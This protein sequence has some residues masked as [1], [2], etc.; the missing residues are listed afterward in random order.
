M[1]RKQGSNVKRHLR[2]KLLLEQLENRR[3]LIA[4][5]LASISGLVFDDFMG[6][7][8][9]AGEEVAGATLT[10]HRDNGDGSFQQGT[11]TQVASTSTGSD[12]RYKFGRLTAGNYF[13]LQDAQ[14]ASGKTLQRVVSPLITFSADAV[15]GV[16]VREIDTF[17]ET[18]QKVSDNTNDGIPE[19]LS[20]S[21]PE[22]IGGE[23]DM[24]VNLTSNTGSI[25][26]SANDIALGLPGL[27]LFDSAGN[28]NGQRRIT[29]DGFDADA[30]SVN[31][32]GLGDTDLTS[33]S[34]ALGLQLRMGADLPGGQAVVRLYSNDN[35]ASTANRYSTAT[36]AI[37]QTG[38]MVSQKEFIPFTSFSPTSGGG[39]DFANIGAIELEITGA[40]NVNGQ[41]DII[42]TVGETDFLQ[43]F[44]NFD[45]ADL[46]LVKVADD[47]TPNINQN[48][49]F[50]I[51]L[52]NN[53]PDTATNVSV[54]DQLPAGVI[55]VSSNPTQGSYASG[56]GI[57]T[58][59]TVNS[60]A[61]PTLQL[62]GRIESAGNR[63]NFA[64]VLT[65]D[66]YDPN[67]TPGNGNQAEENDQA[68]V[69][70]V[71]ESIDLSL[72]KV[73]EPT[74]IVIGS[75]VTFTLT[76]NNA[77]PNTATGV[78]VQDQ[79][80]TGISFVSATPSQGNYNAQTA[81][82]ELGSVPSGAMPTLLLV[83]RVDQA[84]PRTN[85]AQVLEADQQD[86]DSTPGNNDPNEDDQD[87]VTISAPLINLSLDKTVDN[88]SP[89]LGDNLTFTLS[90]TNSGPDAGTDIQV[91]DLL[92]SGLAYVSHSTPTGT[93]NTATGIWDVGS[94]S[95]TGTATLTIV[96]N[97]TTANPVTNTAEVTAADQPDSNSTPGN[98]NPDEDDQSSVTVAAMQSDL[99]LE[100]T[101]DIAAPNLGD[102]I[103]FEIA[104]SNAGPNNATGVV[105]QDVLPTGLSFVSFT[106][107]AGNYNSANSQWTIG[108]LAN[109]GRQTLQLLARVD[110]IDTMLNV[111]EV[112]AA[113]QTDPN[114]TPGNNV[115]SENDQ[116][117][118]T[119]T[120][121]QSDLSLTK[122][123]DKPRAN[124][125]ETVKFTV[126][127]TNDGPNA[128][129]NVTVKDL[130][131]SGLSFVSSD[132]SQ[133]VY[134]SASGV[135]TVGTI[136]N[137]GTASL[138]LF[139]RIE[140]SGD[141]VN[142]A[143]VLSADQ[144]DPDSMPGN[145]IAA[146]DDQDSASISPPVI[147]LSLIKQIDSPR[148]NLG[149]TI[150]YTINVTNDGPDDATGVVVADD[151]PT[152]L[153]LVSSSATAG[154]Y[155][156]NSGRWNIGT[157]PL[158]TTVTLR[159]D[160]RLN[161][162]VPTT[163]FAEV[164]KA[165]QFD[166][167]SV[168]G[169]SDPNE[170]DYSAVTFM[171]AEANLSLTKTVDDPTPNFGN[172]VTFTV[173]VTNG[174]IDT[175]T[176]VTV[177]DLLPNGLDYVSATPNIGTYNASTGIWTIGQL[178]VAQSA[179][180][181]LVAKSTTDSPVVNTA[182]VYSSDQFDP[183][184][185]P[186][187]NV[188]AED[189][190][191]SVEVVGQL[192][193]LAL[194]KGVDDS[195]PNVGDRIQYTLTLTN[196]KPAQA[197]GVAVRD[198][199]PAGVTFQS[200]NATRGSYNSSTGI[201]TI[202][203]VN[204]GE[205]VTLALIASVDGITPVV[206]SAEVI[207][208]NQPDADSTPNNNNPAE[209]DQASITI[210]PQVA[211][212]SVTKA[213]NNERPNVGEQVIFNIEVQ[214]D[215]PDAATGV[216]VLDALPEGL[217]FDAANPSQ[218]NYN[219]Q[220]GIW[221]VGQVASQRNATLQI[222]ATVLSIGA[223]T[224]SAEVDTVDQA[225]PDSSPGN[226][227]PSEDDQASASIR[228]TVIDL[229]LD[230]TA[231]PFR[232]SVKGNLTYTITLH[233]DGLD[234]ATGV[235]VEETLPHGVT[236]L[237]NTPSAG[238]YS[239]GK[240]TVPTLAPQ[241]SATLQIIV[242]VDA[243]G[244]ITNRVQVI[245]ADQF[246]FDSTPGNDDGIDGNGNDEDDQAST[247]VTTASA[248]LSIVKRVSNER[249]GGGT[250]VTYTVELYN[251]GPDAAENVVV[252][253]QIPNGLTFVSANAT[254]GSYNNTTGLWTVPS[255]GEDVTQTLEIVVRVTSL[256]EKINW[257]EV[258]ASS[259]FDPD[260]TPANHAPN[261]DD[262]DS[263]SLT[264]E[265]I[266][267]ALTKMVDDAT[268]N[269]GQTIRFTLELTNQGPST[270]TGVVVKDLLPA[271][272]LAQDILPSQGVYDPVNGLWNV[273][274]V[275]VGAR[276]KL[277]L[278]VLVG[279]ASPK[280]NVA[281]VVQADQPDIDSK[282]D[283][284]IPSEDDYA[285][286]GIIPQIADL[287]LGMTVNNT[288]PN[289]NQDLFYTLTLNNRGPSAATNIVVRDILPTGL[290]FQRVM[291]SSGTYDLATS[292]WRIPRIPA[293]SAASLQLVVRVNSKVP[294]Q[295]TAEVIAVDQFDSDSKPDNQ[296][297]TEDDMASVA[298]TPRLID[299]SMAA[300]V[301]NDKPSLGEVIQMTLRV[302]NSGPDNATGLQIRVGMPAGF[303]IV[304]SRPQ[305]GTFNVPEMQNIWN[306]GSLAAGETV[307][308]VL[309]IRAGTRG[310]QK[311]S[312]EV[313]AYDQADIDSNPANGVPT[314]DDQMD[315]IIR[316]PLFSKRL[317]LASS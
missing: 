167:D 234:T 155:D 180:L 129:T 266:D 69:S 172:N 244:E 10:L 4:S 289:Q 279:D 11:D 153:I 194:T 171:L 25:Q 313:I 78:V 206:N 57:W 99:S 27:L 310:N 66:Q 277:N 168:P 305:R 264:A 104:V 273:G 118:V 107:S 128:A 160:A 224:N 173:N 105:V 109:G 294:L 142:S 50:T 95:S 44:D 159:I 316:V 151:L 126:D 134:D 79:L 29:W 284:G 169:N 15:A 46:S 6:N 280:T 233:N 130:L 30:L 204:G 201:W 89:N 35:N 274:S 312:M 71:T 248:D 186:G 120:P 43:D 182:E 133:G 196:S 205:S 239:N 237:E 259:E 54:I 211:D 193:D 293:K 283:N 1:R 177:L 76:L 26:L 311:V 246:D 240:W 198:L 306:V 242:R 124:V 276:P 200:S 222:L 77:G 70:I 84:G 146:E 296:V 303:D 58:V 291:A 235:I 260:S 231:T 127:V 269:V 22:V 170:D 75:N 292:L 226:N 309:A 221:T 61:S 214:N 136:A 73:A 164:L 225:D 216:S 176:G 192:I 91:R 138:D 147:D 102:T 62:V 63:V 304:S 258:I 308:L 230:K 267:L 256:G 212:L 53:G 295:N 165:D 13:V 255:I 286:V 51:T 315:L 3:L 117:S 317:I 215:G 271:G 24:F 301:S 7:G 184:S 227:I 34:S 257:A 17:D 116:D 236:L 21:A 122:V 100:K 103:T 278:N 8:Y 254:S 68:S 14:T 88:A 245:A 49:T 156:V 217:S 52:R 152:G 199:L 187:N 157:I 31:D 41:A 139:G 23:R 81:R 115:P 181:I 87:S 290:N 5:D 302:T 12:G 18:T 121:Q 253:D 158:K 39:A 287:E 86:I 178:A 179:S 135:W 94:L 251:S 97:L 123:V 297:T 64:E 195:T 203:N 241:S 101:V 197:T 202:G 161:T 183:N 166:V 210:T 140:T 83:G 20:V 106:A 281:E 247:T 249:P 119:I 59:G 299:V 60:G 272:L 144:F 145:G 298:I 40:A 28:G 268:P 90:L 213:V 98:N 72:T 16:I 263:A 261:E 67:S 149:Q 163:N 80:P 288:T 150:R 285:Q 110:A 9:D 307:E 141:K 38:G 113:D 36:L 218:G 270:A 143:E 238:Q 191:G 37:P 55:F 154:S 282:P 45:Q 65:S 19:T 85:T 250:N 148:P 162:T 314:E 32:I 175:A 188:P 174:G 96:A 108:N 228:P 111:S 223:K 114:S 74:T 252:L 2:R 33:G 275:A 300:S 219:S 190:Q 185:T 232:P 82:W 42:G 93:Y 48:V 137:R 262:Q 189:D 265:V 92:P 229:S 243:P 56:T 208:A 209:D 112:L 47:L 125:G 207:A 132:P 220:T 131:P